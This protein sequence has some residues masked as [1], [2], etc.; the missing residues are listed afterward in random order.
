MKNKLILVCLAFALVGVTG[1]SLPIPQRVIETSNASTVSPS[2]PIGYTPLPGGTPVPED[3][4]IP[5]P[6]E[7]IDTSLSQS[8]NNVASQVS[9]DVTI[10][11]MRILIAD[12]SAIPSAIAD[13]PVYNNAQ[14]FVEFVFR[15]TNGSQI[16]V[17]MYVEQAKIAVNDEPINLAEYVESG[18]K[19]GDD[20]SGE[21]LPGVIAIGYIWVGVERT[22]WDQVKKILV[23]ID[24]PSDLEDNPLGPS[25]FF[26]IIVEG[27]NFEP[28]PTDFK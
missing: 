19:L 9:A 12:R 26:N 6:P 24:P 17:K 15:V 16:P 2:T 3:Q 18:V 1:C 10:E 7:G 20:L 25:Y 22:S 13:N 11:I 23:K 4:T 21:Y 14:T 27:W 8:K 5:T 28:I